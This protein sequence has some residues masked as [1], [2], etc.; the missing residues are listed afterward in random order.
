[1]KFTS[2]QLE[3]LENRVSLKDEK[4]YSFLG[5]VLDLENGN[6]HDQSFNDS[7]QTEFDAQV[8]KVLLSHYISGKPSEITGILIKFNKLQGGYAYERAF[9]ARAEQPVAEAFGKK[10]TDL[11]EA[12]K[13]LGGTPLKYG[14]SSIQITTF[15]GI[16]IIYILW[17][18]TEFPAAITILFDQAANNYLPTED[19]AVLAELTSSRLLRAKNQL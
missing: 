9:K 18:E 2:E 5:Y 4:K 16:P 1:M 14:D 12:A 7:K 10:P 8:L 11:T 17:A 13:K 19:L 3:K 6:L 15:K